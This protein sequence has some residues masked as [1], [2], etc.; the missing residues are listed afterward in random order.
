MTLCGSACWTARSSTGWGFSRLSGPGTAVPSLL[1]RHLDRLQRSAREL[2]LP[3][4]PAQLPDAASVSRLI[5]ASRT[6]LY[7][8]R[9]CSA[10]T[11][12]LGRSFGEQHGL[13]LDFLDDS[14]AVAAADPGDQVRSSPRSIHGRR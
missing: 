14:G 9:R 12:A 13:E 5:D 8:R 10:Q 11:H 3:L 4:E 6:S 7:R 1:D 2:G